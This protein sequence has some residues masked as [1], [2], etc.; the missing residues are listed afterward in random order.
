MGFHFYLTETGKV[1]RK[2]RRRSKRDM[3]RKLHKF[4]RL[5]Q[6]G[7]ISKE[8]ID[9]SFASWQGHAKHGHTYHLRRDMQELYYDIFE[10]D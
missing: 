7:Q 10:E 4:K 8:R 2:L 1:I 6:A 5:H 3:R 9:A